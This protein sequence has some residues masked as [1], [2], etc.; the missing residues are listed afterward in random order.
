MATIHLAFSEKKDGKLFGVLLMLTSLYVIFICF[1]AFLLHFAL[2]FIGVAVVL[3]YGVFY[4]FRALGSTPTFLEFRSPFEEE[5]RPKMNKRSFVIL[6]FLGARLLVALLVF[7]D[8]DFVFV[9]IGLTII[10]LVN[11]KIIILTGKSVFWDKI[12][13]NLDIFSRLL[14]VINYIYLWWIPVTI[15]LQYVIYVIR[16]IDIRYT[17]LRTFPPDVVWL[18]Y[19]V[20]FGGVAMF[21]LCIAI[22]ALNLLSYS[23][24]TGRNG[25]LLRPS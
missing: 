24:L 16:E 11:S 25:V 7:L 22:F 14:A 20:D 12:D 9:A 8:V 1:N 4:L 3:I 17:W 19:A 15:V 18:V 10:D 2:I 21:L 6:G 5:E 23:L 13:N